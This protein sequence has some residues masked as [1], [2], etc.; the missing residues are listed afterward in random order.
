MLGGGN[1]RIDVSNGNRGFLTNNKTKGEKKMIDSN[2]FA[3]GESKWI[4]Y[5]FESISDVYFSGEIALEYGSISLKILVIMLSAL[6]VGIIWQFA[7]IV[8]SN[9][10]IKPMATKLIITTVL[11]VLLGTPSKVVIHDSVSTKNQGNLK[12]GQKVNGHGL[13]RY[14]V[15]RV[16]Y[17]ISLPLELLSMIRY[18]LV[19][20]VEDYTFNRW[21]SNT[22]L[23]AKINESGPMGIVLVTQALLNSKPVLTPLAINLRNLLLHEYFPRAILKNHVNHPIDFVKLAKSKDLV[24]YLKENPPGGIRKAPYMDPKTG[25]VAMRKTVD[26]YKDVLPQLASE[27]FFDT[28]FNNES[29]ISGFS[30]ED[31]APFLAQ[32]MCMDPDRDKPFD[33]NEYNKLRFAMKQK[34]M[35]EVVQSSFAQSFALTGSKSADAWFFSRAKAEQYKGFLSG[36]RVFGEYVWELMQIMTVVCIL[37]FAF[38]VPFAGIAMAS[39]GR[40]WIGCLVAIFAFPIFVALIN[41]ALSM[42]FAT[43]FDDLFLSGLPLANN[44]KIHGELEKWLGLFSIMYT[45]GFGGCLYL[46][47][48]VG[49]RF[50][51]VMMGGG[52]IASEA[53]AR[54]QGAMV[55]SK[56]VNVNDNFG[57]VNYQ[58]FDVEKKYSEGAIKYDNENMNMTGVSF[59]ADGNFHAGIIKSISESKSVAETQSSSK[60]ASLAESINELHSIAKERA[61]SENWSQDEQERV[62]NILSESSQFSV[63]ADL[64]PLE[65]GKKILGSVIGFKAGGSYTRS[66]TKS[67]EEAQAEKRAWDILEKQSQNAQKSGSKTASFQEAY[68][69]AKTASEELRAVENAENSVRSGI[70]V[71]E[72]RTKAFM[73][74]VASRADGQKAL[75]DIKEHGQYSKYFES[76]KEDFIEVESKKLINQSGFNRQEDKVK[77]VYDETKS[78]VG[79]EG[80]VIQ[81]KNKTQTSA[82]EQEKG[83]L[84]Q[85][86]QD[87]VKTKAS[88]LDLE[89]QLKQQKAYLSKREAESNLYDFVSTGSGSG[90]S[91]EYASRSKLRQQALGAKQDVQ[92]TMADLGKQKEKLTKVMREPIHKVKEEEKKDKDSKGGNT[93]TKKTPHEDKK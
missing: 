36:A 53:G 35:N 10:D 93:P 13:G 70:G 29:L 79:K 47:N 87:I 58:N 20:V 46:A 51:S 8:T 61:K 64:N 59:G 71:R 43:K 24:K 18:N 54:S 77:N 75:Q 14:V 69:D 34:W 25:L 15:E 23:K 82:F 22:L 45:A 31:I 65:L 56:A 60:N 21:A 32:L 4:K 67:D 68:N 16:P 83:L 86:N 62:A 12:E 37:F 74:Y 81:N 80:Q 63:G 48:A 88:I 41:G 19:D 5:I 50:A 78:E 27:N 73:D 1:K 7:K 91:P 44:L 40:A 92:K 72:D 28:E 76:A 84:E 9:L 6:V 49:G 2:Y 26:V 57:V 89:N 42:V 39:F 33:L 52:A 38:T 30:R 3:M 55:A 90:F 66:S 17:L 85:R 11:M